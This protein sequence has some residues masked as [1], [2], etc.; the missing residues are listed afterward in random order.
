MIDN[1]LHDASRSLRPNDIAKKKKRLLLYLKNYCMHFIYNITLLDI[2]TI[3]DKTRV[4]ERN[5]L[6]G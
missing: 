4:M 3:V 6:M 5:E 2:L 1:D